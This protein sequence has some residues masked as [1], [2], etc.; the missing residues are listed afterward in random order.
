M[1]RWFV[2]YSA[3]LACAAALWAQAPVAVVNGASFQS[4]LPVAPGS[5]AQ[6]WGT[7]AGVPS[8]A[9]DLSRLPLPVRLGDAEVLVE[10]TPAPLYAVSSQAI[11]F[12]VPQNT[13]PGRRAIQVRR[14]GQVLGQGSFHV[15]AEAPGIFFATIDG[16]HVG[17][18]RNQR[19]AF[20]LADAPARRGEVI[21]VALTGAGTALNKTVPDGQA[22]SDLVETAEKPEVYIGV[23]PG[24][25]L[26][27][28]LM[29]LFPGLWQINVRIPDKSYLK[30]PVPLFVRYRGMSSNAVIFW[31]E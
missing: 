16:L 15:L 4:G 5:Y 13:A 22:P 12:L 27:S 7:F 31:T 6:V 21:T 19:G 3:S 29:P 20:A 2:S 14:A 28:G 9:A 26:F 1:G 8:Q 30:G 10:G 25:V 11:A 24:E 17:G 18:V 23:D